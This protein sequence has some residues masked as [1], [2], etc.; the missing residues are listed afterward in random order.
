MSSTSVEIVAPNV[1]FECPF[2]WYL[3]FA[4]SAGVRIKPNCRA[5]ATSSIII[6]RVASPVKSRSERAMS[7]PASFAQSRSIAVSAMFRHSVRCIF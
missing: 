7:S 6:L 5:R 3:P 4:S 2:S 1:D